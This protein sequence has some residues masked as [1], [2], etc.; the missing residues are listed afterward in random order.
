MKWD[1]RED[2][3]PTLAVLLGYEL[4]VSDENAIAIRLEY[5]EVQEQLKGE[6]APSAKQLIMKPEAAEALGQRLIEAARLS[7]SAAGST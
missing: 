6:A 2:G 7:S 1:T 3:D 4:F 5:A